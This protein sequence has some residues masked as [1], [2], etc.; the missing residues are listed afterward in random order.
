MSMTAWHYDSMVM[1]AWFMIPYGMWVPVAVRRVANCYTPFTL[2]VITASKLHVSWLLTAWF[3]Y[4]FRECCSR[5]R[6]QPPHNIT[7]SSSASWSR[8]SPP[9][10]FV[11]G[12]VST[13][14]RFMVCRWPQSQ[15][16]DSARPHLWKLARHGPWPVRKRFIRDH[17]WRGRSTNNG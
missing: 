14:W 6:F 7:A 10:N 4:L 3:H 1:T 5:C 11:N 13:M 2:W 16:G 17:V 15:A 8:F 9:S 12:H